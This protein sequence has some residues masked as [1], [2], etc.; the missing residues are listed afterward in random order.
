MQISNPC[1][2]SDVD[3]RG[4]LRQCRALGCELRQQR[5]ALDFGD[6]ARGDI[7]RHADQRLR[8]AIDAAHDARARLDPVHR[9][10]RPDV[11]VFDVIILAFADGP[12][13]YLLPPRAVIGMD[14]RL[15]ILE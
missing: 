2:L 14:R 7:Q 1:R 3:G 9:A 12:V 10:I 8:T 15:Q 11:T 4:Q 5:L 6:L 13:E